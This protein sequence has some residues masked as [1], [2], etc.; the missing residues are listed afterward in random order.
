MRKFL[1]LPLLGLLALGGTNIAF[2]ATT[3]TQNVTFSVAK[4][5]AITASSVSGLGTAIDPSSGSP[6]GTGTGTLTVSSNDKTGFQVTAGTPAAT[7][8]EAGT[9]CTTPNT[10]NVNIATVAGAAATGGTGSGGTAASASTLSTTVANLYSTAPTM[11]G[12]AITAGT[13]YVITPGY[14]TPANQ[15]SCTYT[16][17]VTMTVIAQ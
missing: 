13:T 6:T 3:A 5:V 10:A 8:N 1:F 17:P 7:V 9:G 12:S 15:G 4:V 2:A 16:I 11:I 14:G